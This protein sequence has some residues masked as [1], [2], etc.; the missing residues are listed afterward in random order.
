MEKK[1]LILGMDESLEFSK[2]SKGIWYCSKIRISPID[3]S[4]MDQFIYKSNE[5]EDK[6][7]EID[8]NE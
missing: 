3:F 6:Y 5:L 4:K 7:N 8:E 1:K 2:T